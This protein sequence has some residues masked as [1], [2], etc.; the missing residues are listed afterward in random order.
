MAFLYQVLKDVCEKQPYNVGK[1]TLNSVSSVINKHLCS[2]HEGF[3]K[4]FD[5]LPARI[6]G[7]N[8]EVQEGN[9]RVK[10]PIEKLQ[11]DMEELKKQVSENLNDNAFSGEIEASAKVNDA[12]HLVRSC[13]D[14]TLTLENRLF[15]ARNNIFNLNSTLCDKVR[16]AKGTIQ[17]ERDRLDKLSRKKEN[18]LNNMIKTVNDSMEHINTYVQVE[19]RERVETLVEKLIEKIT[20]IKAKLVSMNH[21]LSK[22]ASN[23]TQWISKTKR[24]IDEV[25]DNDV[26]KIVN[27]EVGSDYRMEIEHVAKELKGWIISLGAHVDDMRM[28]VSELV[29]TAADALKGLDAQLVKD[30]ASMRRTIKASV[31]DYAKEYVNSI[32]KHIGR[33]KEQVEGKSKSTGIYYD[34]EKLKVDI[35]TRSEQILNGGSYNAFKYDGIGSIQTKVNEHSK[36]FQNKANDGSGFTSVVHQWIDYILLNEPVSGY[37]KNFVGNKSHLQPIYQNNDNGTYT[38]LNKKIRD[39]IS[40]KLVSDINGAILGAGT[41]DGK[42]GMEKNICIIRKVCNSFSDALGR[43]IKTRK[44]GNVE[45]SNIA[46]EINN[47]VKNNTHN[48]DLVSLDAAV[49]SILLQLVGVARTAGKAVESLTGDDHFKLGNTLFMAIEKVKSI[50]KNLDTSAGPKISN[51][52][53]TAKTQ[54]SNLNSSLEKALGGD[55]TISNQDV[56]IKQSIHGTFAEKVQEVFKKPTSTSVDL[57]DDITVDRTLTNYVDEQH[58]KGKVNSALDAITNYSAKVFNVEATLQNLKKWSTKINDNI[59]Y[60]V[61]AFAMTGRQI[62]RCLHIVTNDRIDAKLAKIRDE[63][64]TLQ[65]G[66]LTDVL[67]DL[68]SCLE[69]EAIELRDSTIYFIEKYINSKLKDATSTLTTL[70]RKQYVSSVKDLLT[71]FAQKVTEELSPLPDLIEKDRKEGFK[72]FMRALQGRINGNDTSNVNMQLLKEVA[73][74][75]SRPPLDNKATFQKLSKN[76]QKFFWPLKAYINGEIK[77]LHNEEN[78]KN[79]KTPTEE[80]LYTS[81]LGD[82]NASFND[83]LDHLKETN[84]YDSQVPEMLDKLS[85][86][87]SKMKPEDFSKPNTPT[88][89]SVTGGLSQFVDELRKVYISVYDHQTL[90]GELIK[91]YKQES[92]LR[93]VVEKYD[94]TAEGRDLSKVFLTMISIMSNDVSEMRSKCV[95]SWKTFK[96]NLHD[97]NNPLGLCFK[98]VGYA[99]S[100]S[101]RMQNGELRNE[102]SCQSINEKLK[103]MVNGSEKL[104]QVKHWLSSNHNRDNGDEKTI[105]AIDIL[106]FLYDCLETYYRV[107]HV[108]SSSTGRHPSSVYDMLLWLTGLTHNRVYTELTL[109]GFEDLFEKPDE[110]AVEANTEDGIAVGV[111]K[112]VSLAAYPHDITAPRLSASL[113]DVCVYSETILVAVLGYGHAE[114][115]YACDFNTNADKFAYPADMITLVCCLFDIV[116]R[117]HHQLYFLYRQ[118]YSSDLSG[119]ANCWYGRDIGGSNWKCNNIQCPEQRADQSHNQSCNQ[120]CNQT[121]NCGL[122]SPLQ[123][124]LEDGLQGFLPHHLKFEKGK[125]QCSLKNHSGGPC[126]TPMGFGEI[127]QMASHRY[128]GEHI[129]NTLHEFCGSKMSPLTKLCSQL[130]CILPSAPKTLGD[131]FAFYCTLLNEWDKAAGTRQMHREDAFHKAVMDSNFENPQTELDITTIFKHRDHGTKPPS[132]KSSHITG[133][134][135]ALVDCHTNSSSVS[136]HPCGPYLRPICQDMCATFTKENADKYLS[137]IV[138][139]TESFLDLLKQ[140][141][142]ECA[143]NCN[144]T[145]S[146]CRVSKCRNKCT[147]TELPMSPGSAHDESCG[148]IVDCKFM[149]PTF[150]KY[151]FVLGDCNSL[152]AKT[153]KRTCKDL[154]MVLKSVTNEKEVDGHP[155]AKLVHVTIPQFIFQIRAPFIWLNVALWLLS[156]LY[157]IHIMVIRLDLLH[158]KSHLHSPSSHRIAAQSLLAAGRVNKLNRVFYLQ[159]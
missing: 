79:Q 70:A 124:F 152:S 71:A 41:A 54:I 128:T 145:G 2:G 65:N 138:Y 117:V 63:L 83:L 105:S 132:Q 131:M 81:M 68:N 158:I 39:V 99:V 48:G 157:L 27:R 57:G 40:E 53:D 75:L 153:T 32:K 134:L 36:K 1:N 62:Y 150:Y 155:L 88:M 12:W 135:Y 115:R 20:P 111:E 55:A 42:T 16:N 10:G 119:W 61:A 73:D 59:N 47:F 8:R 123:S 29:Q 9:E 76:F 97:K 11:E 17:H 137:W 127:S 110:G 142:K 24:Y 14:N 60:L 74:E 49:S 67:N 103:A 3:K 44:I 28:K 26:Q 78:K 37:I 84:R 72:G 141:Y 18:D 51:A 23:L 38:Q 69:S 102:M 121:V 35:T 122:K 86:A 118:C 109:N 133:D 92:S 106:D 82:I 89:D 64:E 4:L 100:D 120:K 43:C 139:C 154:C 101:A 98:G 46:N 21:D 94:L 30:L 116:T 125:L 93:G 129:L 15:D 107:C 45:I 126:N 13:L 147:A 5:E 108:T 95:Y 136:S 90:K 114:G 159:P 66:L 144:S 148:S 7:Y 58:G 87:I 140:L 33:I 91:D 146:R 56:D 85:G 149:R 143:T 22:H 96:L 6:A 80:T 130:K 31:T 156:V 113:R 52:L 25:R 104:K 50:Q 77:R 34:W 19:I 112:E 151:G